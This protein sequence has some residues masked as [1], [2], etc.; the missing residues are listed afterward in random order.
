[1]KR[2][3]MFSLLTTGLSSVNVTAQ[4]YF[5]PNSGNTWATTDPASLGWCQDS[6]DVLYDYLEQTHSKAFILLKDGRIVLEKY[7]GT[8]TADSLWRWNSAGKTLTSM[9]VGIAQEE[10]YLSI[11]D[12]T[13]D[14]L[15]VGWTNMSPLQEEKITIRHQLTMTSGLAD[16]GDVYCTDPACLNY[17]AD[18][19]TR[20]AYHNGP[21]TLLDSVI[22]VAT[23]VTL[24]QWV[25]QKIRNPIGM[26]G[27]FIPIG[28]NNI[29]FSNAR[30][31]ARFGLL[32]YNQG[33]WNGTPV[34]DDPVYF[35]DMTHSSQALNPSYGYLT[36]LNGQSSYMVPG[37]QFSFPGSPMP[38]AP[39]D[40]Y[41][42]IGKDGQ[43]I[44]C[45]PS[46]GFVLIRMGQND[47][48]SLV[49]TQYNDT[50]WQY[51][52]R[53]SCPAALSDNSLG[54]IRL[55][56]NP[57]QQTVAISGLH[58]GDE[59]LL[60]TISGASLPVRFADSQLDISH[61]QSGIYLVTINSFG[62]QKTIRLQVN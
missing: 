32:L 3:L 47:D 14:Y 7:F 43:L 18:P 36:W 31:M 34:L 40:I 55:Y 28:Y 15:G 1:M 37:L 38:N 46:T 35:H 8:F 16:T 29:F 54:S 9:A 4:V 10:G 26:T 11:S 20:W 30:S 44:N 50:I 53:L 21:Y 17:I 52:Q 27:F 61:L 22:S 60:T 25:T 49:S 13:A 62:Q 2:L 39:A 48:N 56:P 45:S 23:G 58:T 24:N 41:A 12:T 5:P 33:I 51:V 57:A 42:A 19:G 6:I 59:L